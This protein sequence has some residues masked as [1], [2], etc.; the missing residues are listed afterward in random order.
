MN[1]GDLLKSLKLDTWYMVCVYLG[2]VILV[3]SFFLDVKGVTN[4]HLQLISAGIL[5][6]RSRRVEKS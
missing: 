6:Y 5:L 1:P 3:L 2:G 4:A